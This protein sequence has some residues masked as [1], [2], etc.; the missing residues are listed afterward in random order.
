MIIDM[1][2]TTKSDKSR[3]KQFCVKG[4]INGG[5]YILNIKRFLQKQLPDI[6]SFEKEYLEKNI[7]VNNIYGISFNNYFIDIGIPEDYERA[8]EELRIK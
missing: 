6:F 1:T 4:L 3:E 2:C 7:A 8:Q 5:V